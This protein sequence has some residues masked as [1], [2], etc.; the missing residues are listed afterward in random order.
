MSDPS[1]TTA[2][3]ESQKANDQPA[4]PNLKDPP[5]S[6]R[7]GPNAS[8][9]G[10]RQSITDQL[11]GHPPSPRA[12]RQASLSQAAIHELLNRPPAA[13]SGDPAFAGRDWKTIKVGEL[14]SHQDVSFV[15]PDVDIEEAT[16]VSSISFRR[17]ERR[18]L[19]L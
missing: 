4:S 3:Q 15:E 12:Q 14:V 8:I 1:S 7:L 5:P 11:R 9:L 16:R 13:H 10:H 18:K 19:I 2:D 17:H 6:L